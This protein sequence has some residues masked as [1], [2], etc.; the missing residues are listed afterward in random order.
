MKI[1]FM[2]TPDFAVPSLKMLLANGYEVPAVVTAPDKPGGRKGMLQSAV[3]TFAKEH[4]LNILQPGN[5][6]SPEF[7][8]ELKAL[9]ADLQIVVAFRMLPE[10][11]WA[12]PRLG[13]MNLHGSLLPKYRGAAPINWAIIRGEEETGVTT[14]L[15]QHEIDTG[16]LLFQ[17]KTP[18]GENETA[19]EVYQR[20]MEIGAQL[21]LRSV[22][23]IES[24][25]ARPQRQA[26]VEATHA[27]KIHTETC[28]I[29]FS[30]S[31]AAVHN[32]IRGMSPFPGAWT[33]HNG[34]LLKI[35]RTEKEASVTAP[36]HA[37][38]FFNEG[39]KV[40]KISTLDGYVRV[41]ELQL[42]GK[43]RMNAQEF[44]NGRHLD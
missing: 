3:K 31:T 21:V 12:M 24:G 33:M 17:E 23:A 27:P 7:L 44:L 42:E 16:D 22:K 2:G 32:F 19:G 15:L 28:E 25:T 43:R 38:L 37:G 36:A 13:T 35:F 8:A 30:K 40:L 18:I 39:N 26:D 1:V 9:H 6:K 14:F 29:D 4:G 10:A 11:V 5:L 34:K 20:L 41:L